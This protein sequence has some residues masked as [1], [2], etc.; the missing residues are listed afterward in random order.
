MPQVGE[1]DQVHVE[2]VHDLDELQVALEEVRE[3][4][5]VDLACE[6][7]LQQGL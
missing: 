6:D 2:V 3:I 5:S 4:R 1:T 7:E